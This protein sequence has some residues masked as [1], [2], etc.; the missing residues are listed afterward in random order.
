ML[1]TAA[2]KDPQHLVKSMVGT[3]PGGERSMGLWST[4][5]RLAPGHVP[6]PVPHT[7]PV[8][9]EAHLPQMLR[10]LAQLADPETQVE[11]YQDP[12][13]SPSPRVHIKPKEDGMSVER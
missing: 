2:L 8:V 4:Y 9:S 1:G 7:P 6:G 3:V 10:S 13:G 11:Q 5:Q 12:P